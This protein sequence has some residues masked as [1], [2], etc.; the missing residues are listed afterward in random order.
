MQRRHP[1]TPLSLSES[2]E[3]KTVLVTGVSGFLGKVWLSM[4]L[5]HI[6]SFSHLYLVIRPKG[7][8][9]GQDRFDKMVHR[10][11]AFEPW[12]EED[13]L[14]EIEK[15]ISEK[16]TILEGDV[17]QKDLGLSAYQAQHIQKDLDL[18]LNISGLVDFHATLENAYQVNV[19]GLLNIADFARAC[20]HAKLVHV[21]TCYVAGE[22]QGAIIESI[23]DQTP[24]EQTIEPRKEMKWIEYAVNKVKDL[25]HGKEKTNEFSNFLRTRNE[26]RN[27]KQNIKQFQKTLDSIRSKEIKKELVTLGI[28]RAQSMGFPNTY[29]Y[30]K[31]LAELLL[32]REFSDLDFTIVRPSIVESSKEYPFP[33]W[34]EGFNT[35]GPIVYLIKGWFRYFPAE[36][37]HP[38]DVI[39]VDI[40]AKGLTIVAG[41]KLKNKAEKVYHL[42]SSFLNPFTIG[43][44]CQF[45]SDY[46]ET[47]YRQTGKT[48]LERYGRHRK[49]IASLRDHFLSSKN[50]LAIFSGLEKHCEAVDELPASIKNWLAPIRSKISLNRRKLE[51]AERM[52]SIFKPYIHDFV[53][54]YISKNITAFDVQESFWQY[55][56]AQMDWADYW[57]Q[58][59]MPGLQKWC[60]PVIEGKPVPTMHPQK[61]FSGERSDSSLGAMA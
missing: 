51:Q 16:V 22:A 42:S 37:D 27:K 58:A 34:N 44:A 6:Q 41:A 25:Y 24:N 55:D 48:L 52:L 4:F 35:S 17:S 60:F 47:F 15:T 20:D 5:K 14:E 45:S 29:T 46:Y 56:L 38:F 59:Q 61:Q 11:F 26:Q 19:I 9:S 50:L 8:Q 30:T 23:K 53:Q 33:G 13:S 36:E 32:H 43:E 10:S 21:S 3:N 31:A 54:I 1:H 57:S 2:F 28:E 49:T 18:F 39:P 12:F 40:I 7:G